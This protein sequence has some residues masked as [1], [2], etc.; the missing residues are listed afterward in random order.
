MPAGIE[1]GVSSG[2]GTGFQEAE[3]LTPLWG[4]VLPLW[5]GQRVWE[6]GFS[7]LRA[8]LAHRATWLGHL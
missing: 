6:E 3:A 5:T 4:P 1:R 7:E 8:M 2:M